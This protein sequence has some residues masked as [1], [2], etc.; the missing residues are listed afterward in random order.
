MFQGIHLQ[1]TTITT[2]IKPWLLECI[3]SIAANKI[4]TTY[5]KNNTIWYTVYAFASWAALGIKI[6]QKEEQLSV[7]FSPATGLVS[8][9]ISIESIYM[10]LFGKIWYIL[11]QGFSNYNNSHLKEIVKNTDSVSYDWDRA[12]DFAFL[13][14]TYKMFILLSEHIFS[15][16]K[17]RQHP[18]LIDGF[19]KDFE[20]N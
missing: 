9:Y 3:Y 10:L 12:Q 8:T 7:S 11:D 2:Y 20:S 18:L 19:W 4:I 15:N 17:L 6:Q 14:S 13:I 16:K 1:A 5:F